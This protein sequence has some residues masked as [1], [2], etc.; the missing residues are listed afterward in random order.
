ME[1][2]IER[3]DHQISVRVT[4]AFISRYTLAT[5][6]FFFFLCFPGRLARTPLTPEVY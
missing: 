1:Q 5:W 3:T 2:V 4:P 6:L